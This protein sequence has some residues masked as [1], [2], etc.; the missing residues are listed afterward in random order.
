MERVVHRRKP[1]KAILDIEAHGDE[2]SEMNVLLNNFEMIRKVSLTSPSAVATYAYCEDLLR[3]TTSDDESYRM[4]QHLPEPLKTK[5]LQ[6]SE[7][8]REVRVL[9]DLE[10]AVRLRD[11]EEADA[12]VKLVCYSLDDGSLAK[13]EIESNVAGSWPVV[14]VLKLYSE[15]YILYTPQ[16]NYVDG[17]DPFSGEDLS[18]IIPDSLISSIRLSLHHRIIPKPQVSLPPRAS[19]PELNSHRDYIPSTERSVPL[20]EIVVK[21]HPPPEKQTP[22]HVVV[23][24]TPS[25]KRAT[26]PA[27]LPP[28]SPVKTLEKEE[29]SSEEDFTMTQQNPG[30]WQQMAETL[31]YREKS[32]DS[33]TDCALV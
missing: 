8:R 21:P 22:M 27:K 2:S 5:V 6:L 1:I 12:P 16:M 31:A 17:Y 25:P 18:P 3:P 4:A 26:E 15:L 11:F 30:S 20:P 24:T 9:R 13:E 19:K 32:R 29:T 23:L 7:N 33:C 14:H 10:M 28:I